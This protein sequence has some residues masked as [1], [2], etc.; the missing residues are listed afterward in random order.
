MIKLFRAT[1][2]SRS[3][4]LKPELY[5]TVFTQSKLHAHK[6]EHVHENEFVVTSDSKMRQK[7]HKVTQKKETIDTSVAQFRVTDVLNKE[8][9]GTLGTG[10][11]SVRL[12][13][14]ALEDFS[15]KMGRQ[16]GLIYPRDAVE[17]V[18]SLDVSQGS[19][20]LEVGTGSG[21]LTMFLSRA[22]GPYGRIVTVEKNRNRMIETARCIREWFVHEDSRLK[23]RA[24]NITWAHGTEIP[25]T[26]AFTP[27]SLRNIHFLSTD[28]ADAAEFS[29]LL[30]E[31]TDADEGRLFDALSIDVPEP[32]KVLRHCLPFLNPGSRLAIY[33]PNMTQ[34]HK[35]VQDLRDIG[36]LN[37]ERIY[38][39]SRRF[40][41]VYG[42]GTNAVARPGWDQETFGGF[43]MRFSYFP[44]QVQSSQSSESPRV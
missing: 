27:I 31:A 3:A 34:V 42:R 33:L 1:R 2:H 40:W 17:I 16:T 29:R 15:V 9:T 41:D 12:R 8:I 23:K 22:A 35:A 38:E 30:K 44:G 24:I 13:Y 18:N 19:R 20:V 39:V 36:D 32:E 25:R 26:P 4:S 14:P 37:R 5:K 21:S 11:R 6:F 10:D 43:L 28:A 7:L